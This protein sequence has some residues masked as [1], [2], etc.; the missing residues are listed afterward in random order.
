MRAALG[1]L[2]THGLVGDSAAVEIANDVIKQSNDN[3]QLLFSVIAIRPV[4]AM[5]ASRHSITIANQTAA[6]S[7]PDTS[8]FIKALLVIPGR[9]SGFLR[10]S[11]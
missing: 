1:S 5:Y 10:Y 3:I 2:T 7:N 6:T 4:V 11:G 8:L 9:P